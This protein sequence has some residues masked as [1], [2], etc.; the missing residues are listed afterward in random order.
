MLLPVTGLLLAS[1]SVVAAIF[2]R[3]PFWYTPFT[4]GSFLFFDRL[5]E[6][7]GGRSVMGYIW[8][9]HRRVGVLVYAVAASTALVVDVLFGRILAG[10]WV[11]PFWKGIGNIAAPVLFHYPFGFL[12]LYATFQTARGV[13]GVAGGG[14][15]PGPVMWSFPSPSG[16]STSKFEP[17]AGPYGRVSLVALALCVIAP[18]VNSWLNANRGEVE[19]I[20]VVMLVGTVAFDGIR[21]ALTGHSIVR[22]LGEH[23]R[24]Y[25]GAILATLAWA[26]LINEGPNVFAREWVYVTSPFGL[27]L[28]LTL[29]LGW[30]FLLVVSVTVYETTIALTS[31]ELDYTVNS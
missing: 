29:I 21:E 20:F 11:Y 2:S 27:P 14:R 17:L 31:R 15:L 28:W 4:I 8:N 23:G 24:R 1:A 9:G 3:F 26:I 16:A 13:L 30:P 19:L 12:S 5:A 18:L 10:A 6:R 22:E 7:I 25:A